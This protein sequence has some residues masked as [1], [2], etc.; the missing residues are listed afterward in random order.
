M[1]QHRDG[2]IRVY[3]QKNERFANNCVVEIDRF[4]GGSV[5][6]WGAI[7]YNRRMPLVLVSG[8]LTVQ[9]GQ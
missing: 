7:T 3:K 8:N 2:R 9:I 4:G 5:M 6:M 1:L